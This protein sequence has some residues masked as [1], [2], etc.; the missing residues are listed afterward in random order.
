MHKVDAQP[1]MRSLKTHL[2]APQAVFPRSSLQAAFIIGFQ[3][4]VYLHVALQCNSDPDRQSTP[5]WNSRP[6]LHMQM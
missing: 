5:E 2:E 3:V 6:L 1:L 4:E